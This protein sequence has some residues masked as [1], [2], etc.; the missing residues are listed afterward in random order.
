MKTLRESLIRNFNSPAIR[1]CLTA[2]V[3]P[4]SRLQKVSTELGLPMRIIGGLP[5]EL[6][7]S[8]VH[9]RTLPGSSVQELDVVVEGEARLVGRSLLRQWGGYLKT[10]DA[11]QTATWRMP[12]ARQALLHVDLITARSETYPRP[13]SLPATTPGT[14]ADDMARRDFSVNTLALDVS[15]CLSLATGQPDVRLY[16]HPQALADLEAGLVR[17]LH[18]GSFHDDPT[19][20]LRA[21]RYAQRY[22]HAIEPHS[23]ALLQQEVATAGLDNLSPVRLCHEYQRI[24][25]ETDVTSV[26]QRLRELEILVHSDIHTRNWSAVRTACAR[27]A[28]DSCWREAVLWILLLFQGPGQTER[29]RLGLPH[30]TVLWIDQFRALIRNPAITRLHSLRPSQAVQLLDGLHPAVLQALALWMPGLQAVVAQYQEVWKDTR[31]ILNGHD[32]MAMGYVP[33]PELGRALHR[34][35]AASLDGNVT[36][37]QE[38]VALVRQLL[39][40]PVRSTRS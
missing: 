40:D 19:R 25:R 24:F 1:H 33:G 22:G 9:G 2:L 21:V 18:D 35:H 4:L 29:E 16:H 10:H 38:E 17:V 7:M 23:L 37:K 13:G 11:F 20:I 14:F 32:L 15:A 12:W 31:S 6:M 27:V 3:C 8:H 26:L 36:T 28:G 30:K 5:R 39:G 34:L